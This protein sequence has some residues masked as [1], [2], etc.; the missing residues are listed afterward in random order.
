MAELSLSLVSLVIVLWAGV[1][2]FASPCF[3]PVV[4]VFVGYLAGQ[5]GTTPPKRGAA[6]G[7]A[8]AFMLAFTAVFVALWSLVGLIGW[9]VGSYRD[10]LRIA[11]GVVL[12]IIGLHMTGLISIPVLDRVL[13]PRY[14]PNRQEAPNLRR[15]LLL[16]LAF[17]AGWTPC[18]GPILGGVLGLAITSNSLG[19]GV[20]LMLV[21]SLGLGIPFVLVCAGA[22]ALVNRLTWFV[23]H[24]RAVNIVIGIFLIVVGFL[25]IADLLSRLAGM[26]P[27]PI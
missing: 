20:I 23:T 16:G 19:T 12:V 3:L 5:R 10:W 27:Q 7:Q 9:A 8:L 2:S 15:S 4:P 6:V 25:M 1:V 13:Q 22:S 24:R 18:I 11:G 17:G 26:F 14:S 21:Y